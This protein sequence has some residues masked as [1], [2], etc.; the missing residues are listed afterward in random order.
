MCRAHSLQLRDGAWTDPYAIG[1]R[2][3]A[4]T[5]QGEPS[6]RFSS[7]GLK[8]HGSFAESPVNL[9]IAPKP[10]AAAR[11]VAAAL[12]ASPQCVRYGRHD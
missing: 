6:E 9:K 4:T 10:T 12:F 8:T 3:A 7:K 5:G 11:A 1:P 2:V